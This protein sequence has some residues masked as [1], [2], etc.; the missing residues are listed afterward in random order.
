MLMCL[1]PLSGWLRIRIEALIISNITMQD[2]KKMG[3]NTI[4]LEV[5]MTQFVN[6][7]EHPA[8]SVFKE[9]NL[10]ER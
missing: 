9:I 4:T 6:S 2:L 8:S 3:G 5:K 10:K 1:F 7:K